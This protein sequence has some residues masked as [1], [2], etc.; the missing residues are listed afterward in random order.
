MDKAYLKDLLNSLRAELVRFRYL[1]VVLFIAVSFLLLFLGITWPKKFTTSAVLFADQTTIIEPLLKGSAE[2][3]KID[4]SEQAREIIWTRGIMLA[5]AREVGMVDKNASQEEEEQAIRRIRTGLSVKA[6]GNRS[7]FR[8]SYVANDPDRSFEV[9]NAVVNVF[10][11]DTVRKK[12]AESLGA[13]NFIDAQVQSYKKQLEQAESRL[14]DFN[15]QN[16]DGTESEVST[17]IAALRQQI[18]M[19]NITI[20]ESQA[21]Y[22]TIQQQLGTEGQYLQAKGQVDDL[23]QRRQTLALQLEQL[24]LSY[25]EGYPDIISIRTQIA[26][27]DTTIAKLQSSGDVY[28]DTQ[29]AENPL[30]EELRKQLANADVELRSQ[31]RRMESLVALQEQE[32]ARQQRVAS[33]QAL[34]SELTRDYDVIRKT[35]DDMLQK[36]EAARL[37]MTLDIEGQGVS[38]RIQ[39]PATF[40][41]KPSGFH[42]IHFALIGPLLGLLLPLGL[43]VAYVMFDPHLRSARALQKQLPDDIQLI[44]VIPHYRSPLGDRLLKKDMLLMLAASAIAMGLYIAITVYWHITKG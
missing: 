32:F 39:E 37:S 38:Y 15:S 27:L 25:E 20:E 12:R 3:T 10:M 29:K 31:K 42:F 21:R 24:L 22:K 9:L 43:L 13:Y 14:K 19:L 34:L 23:R 8:I 7:Y 41:L 33:N 18:E 44:G 2:M 26:D 17:R 1:C 4:R 40:P 28:A 36:K 30:Y 35:Y 16:T 5:V 6:E 11:E